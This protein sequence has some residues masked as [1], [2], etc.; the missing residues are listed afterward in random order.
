M[1]GE[2]ITLS[3]A[4]PLGKLARFTQARIDVDALAKE[5]QRDGAQAFVKS[6]KELLQRIAEKSKELA[7]VR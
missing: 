7:N 6:W 3:A 4:M 2:G 5:L 1:V